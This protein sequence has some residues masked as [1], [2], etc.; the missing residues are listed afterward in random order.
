MARK[1]VQFNV[2]LR[3]EVAVL[4]R[5]HAVATGQSLSDAVSEIFLERL[6][7]SENKEGE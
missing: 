6:K 5:D 7:P 1:R 4:I 2:W 3:P